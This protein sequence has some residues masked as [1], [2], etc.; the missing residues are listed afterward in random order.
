MRVVRADRLGPVR[1]VALSLGIDIAP[2]LAAMD[3]SIDDIAPG[4]PKYIDASKVTRLLERC[5]KLC[6]APDFGLRVGEAQDI[7]VLGPIALALVHAPSARSAI[8]VAQRNLPLL[9]L[10]WRVETGPFADAKDCT[11]IAMRPTVRRGVQVQSTE[12]VMVFLHRL[13]GWVTARHYEPAAIW[14]QHQ[15]VS[16]PARYEAA[17]GVLP[18]FNMPENGLAISD[19]QL[20]AVDSMRNERLFEIGKVYLEREFPLPSEDIADQVRIL[21]E[22]ALLAGECTQVSVAGTL[23]LHERTLQRRLQGRGVTFEQIK[24]EA[25]QELAARYL[26]RP[27]MSVSQVSDLL[28]YAE[29]SAFSRSCQRWFGAAPTA[30]RRRL[31]GAAAA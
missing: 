28:G 4:S 23:G 17:F 29:S 24:D 20:D 16:P 15:P 3:L 2:Q 11:F 8:E 25:R 27:D 22:R 21:C 19:S 12:R 1:D 6:K 13:F 31:L 26:A 30:V 14:L 5:V 18:R 9:S 7:S 10:A